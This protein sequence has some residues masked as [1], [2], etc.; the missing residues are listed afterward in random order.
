M[1]NEHKRKTIIKTIAIA[2]LLSDKLETSSSGP[3]CLYMDM[4]RTNNAI[5]QKPSMIKYIIDKAV[6]T[7]LA[8]SPKKDRA[9]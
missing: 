4:K 8:F 7:Y 1:G 2:L 3:G 9:T 5:G 6:K